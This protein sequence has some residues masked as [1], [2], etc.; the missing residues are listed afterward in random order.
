MIQGKFCDQ[1]YQLFHD[2]YCQKLPI[3]LNFRYI[4]LKANLTEKLPLSVASFRSHPDPTDPLRSLTKP[5]DGRPDDRTLKYFKEVTDPNLIVKLYK[6]YK[7]DFELFNYNLQGL[8]IDESQLDDN[9]LQ[10][11]NIKKP[12]WMFTG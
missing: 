11:T 4:F 5:L 8:G 7:E 2:N 12:I 3:S 9:A 10:E 6:C 1:C